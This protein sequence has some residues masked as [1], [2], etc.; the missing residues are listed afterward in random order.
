[1][2]KYVDLCEEVGEK[3]YKEYHIERNLNK[4]KEDWKVQNFSLPEFKN[5]KINFIAGFDDAI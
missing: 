5:T 4:M 3:A 2:L 1:M